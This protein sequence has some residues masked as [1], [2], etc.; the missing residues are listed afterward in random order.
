MKRFDGELIDVSV[1][2]ARE[3]EDEGSCS[4]VVLVGAQLER[5]TGGTLKAVRHRVIVED[6]D[7]NMAG[8][9]SPL[10]RSLVFR[11]RARHIA[12][13]DP[14]KLAPKYVCMYVYVCVCVL[15]SWSLVCGP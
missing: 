10:R 4:L 5:T 7:N 12:V 15:M 11:L 6:N 8:N 14:L 1:P 9:G 2:A 3:Q 13:L